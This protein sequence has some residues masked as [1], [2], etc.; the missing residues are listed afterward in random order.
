[1]SSPLDLSLFPNLPPEV[2]KA[3]AAMQ[4]ELSV[5]RAARQHEQA[6]VAEKDAFIAELKE[7]IEK[8]E[9][10]VHDYRRTKFGPKSEKLDPAQMELAL[11][12]LETAIAETQARI[13]AVENKIEVSAPDPDKAVPRKE[14]KARALPEH[15]PRV[16]RV[17]EPESIVCPCGCGN[18]VRIGEDRTERLDRVPARYEVIVTIRP[19]YACPKGRTGVVQARAPAHLL[20][21]SW[22]TEALLAEIAVSKH[23]EHMPLNRQAEVMARHGVPIDRTVLADWMGRTGAAIAPVVDHMAKRLL[24]ES[25]R[26]YVDET[27]APVLDPG[28]GKTKTGYLWAV[29]RDDR[30]W[31]GCAPP[32]VVFHYRPGRKGEYAAEILDGFNGTIQVDAYGGYSHLATLDRV[33]G[34]PLKLA[35]CWAHGR[36]KLIKATPKS[37]SPIVDEALV[38]IAA[39]YK[40]EDSIRGSDPEHRRAVRQDLSLP[41]V[42]AFFAWLAAQAK[43]VSRKSDL[44]KALAYMLTRQDGFRLFLDDGHV[45]IDSNL[46]ENAIRRPAMN[47]RNALF[48]GHDEGGRNWARFASLIGTCKMN[49]I[50]PYAYLC[51]LFTRLANGHLAKDIDA[52]MPWAHAARIKASQ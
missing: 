12:D 34:D 37:G 30:G 19:K 50:E 38:R 28:R 14:R 26:L 9:G 22:P 40:I 10:Q 4:F 23:S 39:L 25:T 21:G 48:A 6:V 43:R 24:W 17:I 46:V 42:D 13:A 33:G 15:L 52:L 31:N 35:F 3:F 36:R 27:T 1:M 18:M 11:E 7:L 29:L 45:D 47:R 44:G 51:D 16:E 20:E 5:E 49:G 2:V 32:G 8:L 41:L